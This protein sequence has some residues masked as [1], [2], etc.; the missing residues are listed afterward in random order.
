M[1]QLSN[2]CFAFGGRLTPVDVA[3]ARLAEIL[4]PVTAPESVALG[5][6]RGR[7]LAEDVTAA[8]NVPPD[9]NSAVDGYAVYFDDLSSDAETRL[10]IVGKAAAGHPFTALQNRGEA[11][12]IFT[13]AL[14]PTG[15]NGTAPDT[16]M[17]QEDCTEADGRVVLRPGIKRGANRRAAGE[18]VRAGSVVLRAGCRLRPQEIGMAAAVGRARL[19]VHAPLKAAIFSTGDEVRDPG[20]PRDPGAIYD[21]NRFTLAALLAGV[22]CAVDDLGILPDDPVA[23]AAALQAATVDHDLIVTSG[24]VSVGGED[25]VRAAV[26][27]QGSLHFWRL[28]IKPGRPV[29][30]GQ[31]GRTP[32]IGLP[33]NPVAAMVTFLRIARPL[34]LRLAGADDTAPQLFKVAA[35]FSYKKK[36]DR[37]EYVR[38]RLEQ[39]NAGGHVA[40]K[41]ERDGAGI[42]SSMVDADGLVELSE[43]T[44]TVDAGDLVDYL[45]FSEVGL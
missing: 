20:T 21:S 13:G 10:P 45:P 2:D 38:V 34:I 8:E 33:G 7:Y 1:A 29:A 23:I 25:H 43:A 31:I 5:V 26:E 15:A 37:R 39:D 24:G 27:G 17:M 40:R 41:F 32:F 11:V 36:R 14:I 19:L 42:L 6:A 44:T 16:V 4:V 9:D 28:A 30:L 18:D 35:G 22:G 3:L 12:R